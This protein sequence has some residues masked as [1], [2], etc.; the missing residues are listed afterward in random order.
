MR[1]ALGYLWCFV[2]AQ[3]ALAETYFLSYQELFTSW[4]NSIE[5]A[6]MPHPSFGNI[7]DIISWISDTAPGLLEDTFHPCQ[8]FWY[9]APSHISINQ[10]VDFIPTE[11]YFY[12]T[13]DLHVFPPVA[14]P[15]PAGLV[16]CTDEVYSDGTGCLVVPGHKVFPQTVF[17]YPPLWDSVRQTL[18]LGQNGHLPVALLLC[19]FP[20]F[21][22]FASRHGRSNFLGY[23]PFGDDKSL[24]FYV[25]GITWSNLFLSSS[26]WADY[27]SNQIHSSLHGATNFLSGFRPL[28]QISWTP[29]AACLSNG[30]VPSYPG[31]FW[32]QNNN[33]C[34]ENGFPDYALSGDAL[35]ELSFELWD[36]GLYNPVGACTWQA[37]VFA[38]GDSDG[39]ARLD[40]RFKLDALVVGGE[41]DEEDE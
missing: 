5:S 7:S 40:F 1:R 11:V 4:S 28:C 22:D 39:R 32:Y 2:F 9:F 15:R 27:V 17:R 20:G 25:H 29:V 13:N 24:C 14:T 36:N 26:N 16:V 30:A 3:V 31:P 33:D 18:Q 38:P 34:D 19:S 21:T 12:R 23:Y 8:E 10:P 6:G 35:N 37:Y 41:E